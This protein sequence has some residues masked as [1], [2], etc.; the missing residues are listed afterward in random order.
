MK[1]EV[2]VI[3]N[4]FFRRVCPI[5]NRA[6]GFLLNKIQVSMDIPRTFHNPA[7]IRLKWLLLLNPELV[8]I[9]RTVSGF[10]KGRGGNTRCRVCKIP[11]QP[12]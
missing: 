10:H 7:A 12:F 6:Q 2:A 8:L 1:R 3:S 9:L 5:L 4:G 11:V